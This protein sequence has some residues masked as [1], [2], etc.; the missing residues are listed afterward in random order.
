MEKFVL[1]NVSKDWEL[2]L[3]SHPDS[4]NAKKG[5]FVRTL[6]HLNQWFGKWESTLPVPEASKP[7]VTTLVN[8]SLAERINV[9]EDVIHT[10]MDALKDFE[11]EK[12]YLDQ[13]LDLPKLAKALGTNHSYLSRVVNHVK[14]KPFKQYLND[15]RI[16][17]AFIELQTNPK[18]RLFTV[19]AIAFD[20]GFRSAES[21]SKKF[22]D[23]YH[24]YPSEFLK[25][26]AAF[27]AL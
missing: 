11:S 19:E 6:E 16:E 24:C 17:H 25:R 5:F 2:F 12:G 15:M 20:N 9:P 1:P 13:E 3:K 26:L 21:F 18:K 4:K 22:K 27:D 14:G 10:L 8:G 7:K 23:R